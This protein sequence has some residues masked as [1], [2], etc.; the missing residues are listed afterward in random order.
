MFQRQL[1][2]GMCRSVIDHHKLIFGRVIILN[3]GHRPIAA[4][5]IQREQIGTF[6]ARRIVPLTDQQAVIPRATVQEIDVIRSRFMPDQSVIARVAIQ[7][8]TARSAGKHIIAKA[9]R[10]P[11]VTRIARQS[12]AAIAAINLVIARAARQAIRAIMAI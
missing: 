6:A 3:M 12:I 5:I 4:P 7:R 2:I 8:V 10:Q 1:R 9:T 11:I